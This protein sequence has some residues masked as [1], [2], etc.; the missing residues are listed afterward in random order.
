MARQFAHYKA[1]RFTTLSDK[2][3]G[4]YFGG[5]DHSTIIYSIKK[6]AGYLDI[7]EDFKQKHETFLNN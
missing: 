3:I 1:S 5:K 4:A 6:I 2:K 7:D